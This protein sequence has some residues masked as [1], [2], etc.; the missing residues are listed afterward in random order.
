MPAAAA[1]GAAN[2][3][4][5]RGVNMGLADRRRWIGAG[6]M[7]A[8]GLAPLAAH[9][10][11]SEADFLADVPLV[12]TASRLAQ[13]TSETPAAVTVIDADMI[14]ASG[15]RDIPDLLRLVPGFTVAYTRD[16]TWGVG[17]HGLADGFS[18]RMQVL[19]DGRSVYTPGF[20]EVPWGTLPL[21]IDDIERI[22]VVRG[23]NSAAYGSNAFFGVINIITKDPAQVAGVHA[24][25]A[26]GDHG[27]ADGLLRVAGS[28]G[29]LRYRLT[30]GTQ[31]RDRFATQV[32]KSAARQL[33]ARAD[34][35]LSATDELTANLAASRSDL[36][37]GRAGDLLDPAREPDA[38]AEHVQL[39]FRRAVDPENEWSL[40]FYHTRYYRRDD[41]SVVLPG[42][43]PPAGVVPVDLSHTQWRDDIEYQGIARTSEALRFVWGAE[44]RWEGVDAPGWFYGQ[45]D[46]HG[47]L[48]RLFGN[49]EW[50]V[51]PQWL[52]NAG[53]MAEHH[54][55]SGFDVSPRLA[56]NWRPAHD[57]AFRASIGEAYRSPTFFEED[58][59]Q[60]FS[61]ADGTP[62]AQR[63][64]PAGSLSAERVLSREVGYVGHF[65]AARLQLDL[66]LFDDRVR[67]LIG[68]RNIA[69]SPYDNRFQAFNGDWADIRGA[70]LQLRAKPVP[71]LDLWAAYA[72][73]RITASDADIAG[74]APRN[75][76]SALGV[77]RLG[78]GW[79]AS[80]GIYRQGAVVWLDDGDRTRA[81]TR[82]DARLARRWK[83]GGHPLEVALVGQNL[84]QGDVAEFRPENRFERRGYVSVTFDW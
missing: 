41:F 24:F 2:I 20:G 45:G 58:G 4:I 74:S 42:P 51:A 39:R 6:G 83:A 79:E 25:L 70:D 54:S 84:N 72:R 10:A 60:R 61:Y 56:V 17:Y 8:L 19:I 40:Q 53:L 80:A 23:P 34:Y 82:V 68:S 9:A 65:H 16:N 67:D 13:P 7:L 49:A 77:I 15:F 27:A 66:R 26:G 21:A 50:R 32:E 22:E 31:H 73:V 14:R 36:H 29:D 37:Q 1:S 3:T 48:Y 63:F 35:R 59:D 62:L 64:V 38:G 12:L 43:F 30:L 52:V 47:A 76:F 11:L 55:L 5:L 78:D 28:Q 46:K 18:R 44:A 81:F 75:N 33:D 69:T 57:H 71:W